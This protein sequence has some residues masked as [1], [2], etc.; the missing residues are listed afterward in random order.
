MKNMTMKPKNEDTSG[1]PVDAVV[2]NVGDL[3]DDGYGEVGKVVG[4]D[5]Y[6][7][8]VCFPGEPEVC[9]PASCKL[10]ERSSVALADEVQE[11][12]NQLVSRGQDNPRL[13]SRQ[14][15]QLMADSR[16]QLTRGERLQAAAMLLVAAGLASQ[17]DPSS[18]G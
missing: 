9:D 7:L 8:R 12:M 18:E 15:A 5:Q 3:V 2:F 1:A 14:V 4:S 17:A 10:Y 13:L 16:G 6:G 11:M